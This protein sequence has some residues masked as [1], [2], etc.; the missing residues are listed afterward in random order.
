MV[1]DGRG[2]VFDGRGNMS[3]RQNNEKQEIFSTALV[4]LFIPISS[5]ALLSRCKINKETV[6]HHGNITVCILVIPWSFRAIRT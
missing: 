2:I 3:A 1:F 5:V 6:F 4:S